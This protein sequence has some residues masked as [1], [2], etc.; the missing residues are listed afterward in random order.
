M[1]KILLAFSLL[2]SSVA[3][4]QSGRI[5]CETNPGNRFFD[6]AYVAANMD[7]EAQVEDL[8]IVHGE[9]DGL[10]TPLSL[11]SISLLNGFEL[12]ASEPGEEEPTMIT[13]TSS[14]I[15][16]KAPASFEFRNGEAVEKRQGFCEIEFKAGI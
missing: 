10:E 16:E 3:F 14:K 8:V 2:G 7:G 6:G 12:V 15:N 4:A 13:I 5:Y 1:K 9:G 11:K